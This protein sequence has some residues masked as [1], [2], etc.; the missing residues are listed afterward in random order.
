MKNASIKFESVDLKW[1]E[2]LGLGEF[3]VVLGLDPVFH[4]QHHFSIRRSHTL[5][6]LRV[7]AHLEYVVLVRRERK[8]STVHLFV[9]SAQIRCTK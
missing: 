9:Q 6:H 1:L 8:L 4:L 3:A 5:R 2:F 7:N